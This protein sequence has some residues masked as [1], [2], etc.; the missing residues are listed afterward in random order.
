MLIVQM[1][2][3]VGCENFL[4][5]FRTPTLLWRVLHFAGYQEPPLYHWNE[6]YLEGQPWYEMQLTIPARTQAPF[7]QE[8]KVDSEGKTP[9]EATQVVAFEV[10]SQIYQQHGDALTGS[11][12]GMFPWV[13]PS[14]TIW[15]QRNHNALIRD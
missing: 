4:M 1:A 10:L 9:W 15:E 12:A 11:A 2:T 14:T 13:D 7:W 6:E 8:W 3:P 5:V